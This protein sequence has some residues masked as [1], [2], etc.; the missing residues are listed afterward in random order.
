MTTD[1]IQDIYLRELRN[2][3]P[4]P[5]S[6]AEAAEAVKKWSAPAAPGL[7]ESANASI[8]E[9]LAAYESQTVEVE[10]QGSAVDGEVAAKEEDWF[11][12]DV[13]FGNDNVAHH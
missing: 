10:G 6:A 4:K 5:E 13:V 12:E 2:Y 8:A 7:P 9:E 3:K 11:E 1:P